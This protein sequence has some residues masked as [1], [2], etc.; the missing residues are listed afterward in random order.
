MEKLLRDT[1]KFIK[2]AFSPKHKLKKEVRHLRDIES[3]IKHCL[4]N[5]IENNYLSKED[6]NFMRPCGNKRGVLYGL[7]KVH[8]KPDEPNRLLPICSILSAI[9]TCSYNLAKLFVCILK[10]FTI[11][12]YTVTQSRIR[13][14]FRM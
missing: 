9:G 1:S 10:E 11:N 5:F 13:F 12:E 3:N 7:C 6:Y 2:V 14:H 4:D 8:K